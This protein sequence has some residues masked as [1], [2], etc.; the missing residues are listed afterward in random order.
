MTP[1]SLFL[2][3]Y[4]RRSEPAELA[5]P[6]DTLVQSWRSVDFRLWRSALCDAK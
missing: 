6:Y 2:P 4:V 5:P 3:E 1:A